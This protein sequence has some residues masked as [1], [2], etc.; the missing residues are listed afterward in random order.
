MRSII[1]LISQVLTIIFVGY[2]LA[3]LRQK[4]KWYYYMVFTVIAIFLGFAGGAIFS[5]I[6][7]DSR[8]LA[9]T[10]ELKRYWY[11]YLISFGLSY[12]IM[13]KVVIYIQEM[14]FEERAI[15]K[16][17]FSQ[18]LLGTILSVL[19]ISVCISANSSIA[20]W[21]VMLVL[22]RGIYIAVKK[23]DDAVYQKELSELVLNK[24]EGFANKSINERQNLLQE[25][26]YS[27]PEF[28]AFAKKY[29][30]TEDEFVSKVKAYNS[31]DPKRYAKLLK[32]DVANTRWS[33]FIK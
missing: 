3:S 24:I 31:K 13:D 32:Y 8:A 17:S 30:M 14:I 12:W 23:D 18:R 1:K 7:E 19:L 6:F 4:Q 5:V 16:V 28:R 21:I 20:F 10:K 25:R 22:A 2:L 33:K 15:L 11:W 27:D 26:V 9:I 29:N